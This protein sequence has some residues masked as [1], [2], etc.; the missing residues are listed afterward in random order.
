MVAQ[1][2]DPRAALPRAR[3]GRPLRVPAGDG[4]RRRARTA[5][6]ARRSPRTSATTTRSRST[7]P[8]IHA[9]GY[10]AL[11]DAL[12]CYLVT[13]EYD[14]AEP[15]RA[16]RAVERP[17]RRR[18]LE[19]AIA[20]ALQTGHGRGVL[21][22]G[23]AG[24]L[25]TRA[26]RAVSRRRSRVDLRRVGRRAARARAGDES[27]TGARAAR[28]GVDERR[29]RRGRPA[30]RGGGE[31][32]RHAARRRARRAA[33]RLLDRLRLRRH[34]ARAVRRVGRAEP[35]RRVRPDEA[36]RRGGRRRAGVDRPLVVALRRDRPQLRP[37]DAAPRRR[38]RRGRRSST[39]SAAARPTSATSRAAMPA[40]VELPF[41][42]YH[43]AAAGDCTWADF[44]EAIFEE[45]GLDCRVRRITTRRVRREGAAPGV[46][47]AALREGRARSCRTG[48][49]G[50]ASASRGC[51]TSSL[52]AM[53][54]LVT[55]GAGFIGSHFVRRLLAAG[56][57]VVVLDKLT[58]AA[59]GGANLEGRRLRAPRGRHRRC[60]TTSPRRRAA[61]T[62]SSTSRPRR[63]STARSS[64][65]P[66]SAAP[67]SSGRRCCSSRC[68]RAACA[69]CRSRPT[70]STATSSRAASAKETDP[71]KPSSPYSVAKAAGDL[72]IPAYVRTFGVNASITRGSNTYGPNQYPEKLI[73]LFVTNA[74]EGKQL[75]L[76]GDGRQIRD[77]LYVEDHCA[78]DRARAARGRAGRGLQRR[79]RRR[80]REHR[81]RERDHRAARR[82]PVAAQARRGP[83][84][85]RPALQPRQLEA[86]RPRLVAAG[87]RSRTGC[88][89]T[90][91]WYRD[92]RAWWEPIKSGEFRAYYERQYARPP[93]RLSGPLSSAFRS[94]RAALRA[95]AGAV[96]TVGRRCSG[97][98][99]SRWSL[100]ALGD[101]PGRRVRGPPRTAGPTRPRTTTHRDD[102]DAPRR[103]PRPRSPSAST[104]D[105]TAPVTIVVSGHGWGHGVGMAQWGAL[106]YAQHGWSSDADPR[107]LLPGHDARAAAEPDG[108]RAAARRRRAR[109]RS[110]RRRPGR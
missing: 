58:Y 79:R 103:R 36:A 82:R 86:A 45:A 67:S 21:I 44:A 6:P 105:S 101:R 59:H 108:A 102:D 78:G 33:R 38:A 23:G 77:W 61:A 81:R 97:V 2:R 40:V 87:R 34:E 109:R 83:P 32:R 15:R 3:P 104:G 20:A 95:A 41:G 88:A 56:D 12:F 93:R 106:G 17:A 54:V 7:S 63:T 55:G 68:A 31:R 100:A 35:A 10:E 96:A 72:H 39:T 28:G 19:H 80:A 5:R 70:R 46:L 57:E 62:R 65:R 92:N 27:S 71:V 50:C 42:V 1:G 22:T 74:L 60:A 29:R 30:G 13:E 66:T 16:R 52:P 84:G 73:P 37:H 11:T 76:Y 51:A 110:A 94:V 89:T 98:L 91:D 90:V 26:R 53:R 18:P 47:G 75:P 25:G 64:A 4:A 9:H 107:P 8:A 24:Q 14:P 85:P 99:S 48:A 49:T 43:V 69:S